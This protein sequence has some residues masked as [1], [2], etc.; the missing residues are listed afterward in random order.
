MTAVLVQPWRVSLHGGHS[1]SFCEHARGDLRDV[2]EAAVA[3]GF[4][5]FGLSEHA[6][7][8]E[9]QF[10]YPSEA[11]KGYDV[12]RLRADFD[13]YARLAVDLVDEYAGRIE[14][15]RGFE[16]EVVPAARYREEMLSLRER[17][18]FDYV[19]GSV[20]YVG[21]ISIDGPRPDFERALASRGGLEP[22]AI[23]YYRTLAQMVD[24]LRPEVVGHLD[25]LRKNAGED[26]V[27]ESA[28]V[29][30]AA[31]EALDAVRDCGAILDVNTAALRKR[32]ETPYPAPWLVDEAARRGI[33][34][35]FGDDS[36]GPG[37]VGAGL[38]EARR[39]LRGLGVTTITALTK[40]DGELAKVSV[41]LA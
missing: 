27:L 8:T 32:L 18:G 24:D 5:T 36:H 29:R 40:R 34:L 26:P 31:F 4:R 3:A 20:H 12:A 10:V 21:E 1:G 23:D 11:A 9:E 33:G 28:P 14:L 13:A 22:L 17:H 6:P 25:L 35:C 2:V 41:P 7:R 16:A 38:D 19:V 15:L 37:D 39:Y 30:R